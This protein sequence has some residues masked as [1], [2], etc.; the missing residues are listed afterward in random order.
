MTWLYRFMIGQNDKAEDSDLTPRAREREG[1]SFAVHLFALALSKVA[2]S[3]LNP[4]LVLAALLQALAAPAGF[5][6][7]LAPVREAGAL[8]PQILI[9]DRIGAMRRSK[10]VWMA[11]SLGQAAAAGGMAAA[12][13]LAE[14]AA[15]G[16]FILACLALFAVARSACSASY[17]PLLG[18]TVDRGHRGRITG[19]AASA[20][21]AA[22]L[23]GAAALVFEIAPRTL[24][25]Q[26]FIILAASIWAVSALIMSQLPEEAGQ[27]EAAAPAPER[28][29]RYG[30]IFKTRWFW[31]FLAARALL[32]ATSFAPPF[33]L[34]AFGATDAVDQVGLFIIAGAAASLVGGWAWGRL[35]DRSSRLVLVATAILAAL[36]LGASGALVLGGR[37]GPATAGA[38]LFLLMLSYEGVRLGRSTY[39]VDRAPAHQRARFNAAANTIM[40]GLLL[41]GGGLALVGQ[42]LGVGAV[43]FIL[44]ALSAAAIPPAFTLPDPDDGDASER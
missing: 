36:S 1:R 6:G 5:V 15:A 34:L 12:A 28:L 23:A 20:S 10:W 44:A 14:G 2:D 37:F 26:G 39:L 29:K 42:T 27:A 41:L 24:L 31:R 32:S 11:G 43:F 30:P 16:F 3:F 13:L 40:G 25:L 19:L 17:K 22:T 9:A 7:L 21:S 8:L 18:K 33:F 35:A 4:K 38:L